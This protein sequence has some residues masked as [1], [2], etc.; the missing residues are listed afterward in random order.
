MCAPRCLV[1]R[2]TK[3]TADCITYRGK[4]ILRIKHLGLFLC[5]FRNF[6]KSDIYRHVC[7]SVCP[8]ETSR[9]PLDVFSLNLIFEF[10]FFRKFFEEIEVSLKSDKSNGILP[11]ELYF[12]II[13][14]SLLPKM[15]NDSDKICRENQNTYSMVY[16]FFFFFENRAFT[17]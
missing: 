8:H 2:L 3:R 11:E 17:K 4:H 15:R 6:A 14:R 10:F 7:P 1:R 16:N 12:L 9:L 5:A 13:S